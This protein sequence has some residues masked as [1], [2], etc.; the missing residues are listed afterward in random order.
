MLVKS[1]RESNIS[2]FGLHVRYTYHASLLVGAEVGEQQQADLTRAHAEHAVGHASRGG[3]IG[4]H[5]YG[6]GRIGVL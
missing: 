6:G 3:G 2:R 4:R 1:R 5:G